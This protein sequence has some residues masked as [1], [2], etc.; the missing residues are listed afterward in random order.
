MIRLAMKSLICK[1]FQF[2]LKKKDTQIYKCSRSL[3]I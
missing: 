2:R 1:E 3:K